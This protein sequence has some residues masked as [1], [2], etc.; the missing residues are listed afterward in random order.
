[1]KQ[2]GVKEES[3]GPIESKEVNGS[4]KQQGVKESTGQ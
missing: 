2:E 3:D 1:M 4:M